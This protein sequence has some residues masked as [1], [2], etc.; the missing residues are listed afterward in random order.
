MR[1]HTIPTALGV[2]LITFPPL[3]LMMRLQEMMRM[4]TGAS[5]P[6]E[7]GSGVKCD[8]LGGV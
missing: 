6:V 2:A 8:R 7:N 5:S 1:D 4:L 3:R